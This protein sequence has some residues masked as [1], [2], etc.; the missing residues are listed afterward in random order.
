MLNYGEGNEKWDRAVAWS[1][2]ATGNMCV[3]TSGVFGPNTPGLLPYPAQH[4]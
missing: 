4:G 3:G 1:S 2:A